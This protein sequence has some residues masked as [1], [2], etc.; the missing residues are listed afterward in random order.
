MKVPFEV[1]LLRARKASFSLPINLWQ[2]YR[3]KN[4]RAVHN[5]LF[6]DRLLNYG[7]SVF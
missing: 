4:K 7:L 5:F 2:E 1:F 3:G 6:D